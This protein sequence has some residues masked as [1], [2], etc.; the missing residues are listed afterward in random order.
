MHVE[1]IRSTQDVYKNSVVTT[2]YTTVIDEKTHKRTI[3]V[4]THEI[5]LYTRNGS[6]HTSNSNKH[7]VDLYV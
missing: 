5:T 6:E 2:L 7:T 3:E 4:T 1:S